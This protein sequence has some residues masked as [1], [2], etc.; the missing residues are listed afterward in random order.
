MFPVKYLLFILACFG[1]TGNASAQSTWMPRT[2]GVTNAL[3]SITWNGNIL[4]AVGNGGTIIN[5]PDGVT[6]NTIVSNQGN[7][8]FSV[9]WTGNQFV[10]MGTLGFIVT[11]SDGNIWSARY[12]GTNISF[13]SVVWTGASI[14][15]GLS[16]LVAVGNNGGIM[17]SSDGTTWTTQSSG[18]SRD[19]NSVTWTGS[20]LVAV[21][22][23]GTIL[24][25]PDGVVWTS[26]VSPVSS[27][28][29]SVIWTGTQLVA[30]GGDNLTGEYA[31]LMSTDGI[32]WTGNR[33]AGGATADNLFSVT[34]HGSQFVT[35]GYF[36]SI[37]VSSNGTTWTIK[38][39]G[40]T[41]QLRSVTW[42]GSQ[43]VTVGYNGTI[44]T[45][46][47][48]PVAIAP[49]LRDRNVGTVPVFYTVS[50]RKADSRK[51]SGSKTPASQLLKII[52]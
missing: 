30:V 15:S 31:Y 35:V 6:W 44:L 23:T 1:L 27:T 48:D 45:S 37:R 24:T 21:G 51:T 39:S 12:L 14:N 8:L 18:T 3:Y 17:T 32:T 36:G 16:K 7:P 42:A 52:R 40:V 50:G 33:V 4:V 2:S 20:Q 19:L 43:Y 9:I 29:Y 22:L 41:S 28:F 46:P 49:H 11:S 25:S 10:A 13:T 34:L 5:S 38:S 47:Q 26:R